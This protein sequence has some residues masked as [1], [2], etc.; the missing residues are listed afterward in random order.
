MSQPELTTPFGASFISRDELRFRAHRNLGFCNYAQE[1]TREHQ[2]AL[3]ARDCRCRCFHHC[4][5]ACRRADRRQH[6][7]GGNPDEP[8][9]ERQRDAAGSLGRRR[10]RLD[11]QRCGRFVHR[12]ERRQSGDAVDGRDAGQ[13]DARQRQRCGDAGEPGGERRDRPG[14]GLDRRHRQ[15]GRVLDDFVDRGQHRQ[16]RGYFGHG[17]AEVILL[18]DRQ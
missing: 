8:G 13:L 9:T 6:Q 16:L 10:R 7:S 5:F 1:K 18:P 14:V 11:R 17:D 4:R 3:F 15:P 2:D 12:C